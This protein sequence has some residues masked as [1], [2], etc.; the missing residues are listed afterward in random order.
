MLECVAEIINDFQSLIIFSKWT[1]SLFT[2]NIEIAK[3][4]CNFCA[5]LFDATCIKR[6]LE[7]IAANKNI[8]GILEPDFIDSAEFIHQAHTL[9]YE[10][11]IAWVRVQY[12]QYF[13]SLSYFSVY[14]TSLW[15]TKIKA[16]Y[17]KG[18]KF[19]PR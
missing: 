18:G 17:E 9:W 7:L 19:W 6:L 15:A 4:K 10:I 16:K 8:H 11:V 3:R 12:D 13:L 1:P 5:V 2:L 14:F